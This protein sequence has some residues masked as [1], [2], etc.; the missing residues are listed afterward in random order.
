MQRIRSWIR[1]STKNNLVLTFNGDT[2]QLA[3]NN[4]KADHC[5]GKS[6]EYIDF[7]EEELGTEFALYMNRYGFID[8]SYYN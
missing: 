1:D 7:D 5:S 3:Q 2:K 6:D 4:D 8:T